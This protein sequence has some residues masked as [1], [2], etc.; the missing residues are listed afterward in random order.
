M[1]HELMKLPFEASALEPYISAETLSYHY[2]KHHASYVTKLNSLIEGTAYAKMSLNQI[3][4]ESDGAVFNNAAQVYN[5]DFY[6]NGLSGIESEP[7]V[8]LSDAIRRDFGSM[9]AFKESFMASG[10]GLFGSGWI[11]LVVNGDR[12]LKIISTPNADTPIRHKQIPL[13][14]CDVWEHA[15]YIDYR[16]GRADYLQSWWKLINWHFVSDNFAA[17]INDPIAGYSQ[18]CN[19]NNAVC[20]YVDTMQENEHTPS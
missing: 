9:G 5:H 4:L 11:W 20:D 7:S 17:L 2:G 19:D 16:N 14:T 12:K 8:E 6:W 10:T 15:Y 13:L 1:H 3:I 18:P